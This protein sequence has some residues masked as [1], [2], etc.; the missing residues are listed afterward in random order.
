MFLKCDLE[1]FL[2]GEKIHILR[3]SLLYK[4]APIMQIKQCKE[5]IARYQG[6]YK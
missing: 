5:N 1:Y 3:N 6:A 2:S 4:Y